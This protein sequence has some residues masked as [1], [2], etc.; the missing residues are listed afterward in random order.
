MFGSKNDFYNILKNAAEVHGKLNK[1][2]KR[3]QSMYATHKVLKYNFATDHYN[4]PALFFRHV[5]FKYV[6]DPNFFFR[7]CLLNS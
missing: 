1:K 6:A 7:Y 5:L 3:S 4:L 2:V